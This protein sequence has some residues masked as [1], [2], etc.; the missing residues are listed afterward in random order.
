M[1]IKLLK[2][3]GHEKTAKVGKITVTVNQEVKAGDVLVNLESKKGNVQVVSEY[4][5]KITKVLIEEGNSVNINDSLFDIDGE[6]GKA[7]KAEKKGYSFGLAKAKKEDIN[8]DIAIIGGGPGGYVAAIRAA[9]LGASVTLIEEKR[10]GGTCLNN[11]CIPTKSFV[12]SAHLFEEI[13]N[14]QEFGISVSDYSIDMGQVVDRKDGIVD[15]L[16]GGIGHLL[17]IGGV[18]VLEG[19]AIITEDLITVKNKK[20]DAKVEA[21][22]III[23]TGSS[24]VKLNIAG[25]DL[26][27]VLTSTELLDLKEIPKSMTIVGG[28]IIGMEFA[29]IFNSL[30]SNV[31]VVEFLDDILFALDTD[32]IE[33]IKYQCEERGIKLHTSSR[34]DQIVETDKGQL[35]TQFIKDEEL[36]YCVG[37]YVL[38][39][40]GRK[41]NLDNLDLDQLNIN[42]N[43]KGNGVAVDESMK[44]SNEK[45]YAIGDITNII[46]LAHVAS[47]QGVVAVENIMGEKSKMHYDA[48]PSAVF[49]SPEIGIVGLSEKEA[50]HKDI[51]YK[52]GVFPF[53]ANGKALTLN[54]GEGFVKVLVNPEDQ[55]I[56]GAAIVGPGATDMIANFTYLIDNKV[57]ANA[58]AH[59]IFAHPTTAEAVHEALLSVGEGAIHFA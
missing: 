15:T 55:T 5:G 38:M 21:K 49:I 25:A 57:K 6:K 48:V 29:F 40:V 53:A 9:Q 3:S 20:I 34:V 41:P 32:V 50:E 2:I 23:A 22:N 8:C 36:Q 43:E 58:L 1:E 14:C 24:P 30:G 17:N 31:T 28:G 51:T 33:T 45:Y 19:K 59:T 18:K 46:Q 16:V 35:I 52:T 42:L 7:E 39:A 10:L 13:K 26:E 4:N 54:E 44:T 56:L 47:H 11:G 12:K 37:D 27:K